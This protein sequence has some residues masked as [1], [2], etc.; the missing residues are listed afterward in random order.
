MPDRS[1]TEAPAFPWFGLIVLSAAVFMSVT[2]EM[3]PTGLLQPISRELGVT[4]PQV[5][6]LLTVFA[7][8]VVVSSIPLAALTRNL[9]RHGLLVVVLL[10]LAVSNLLS[11]IAPSYGF[12]VVARVLGG[13]AH[14]M[15]WIIVTAYAG[16][17]V[18][19]G[20]LGRAVA[21]TAGG[22]TLAYIFGVPLGTVLGQLLGWRLA[23]I[24]LAVLTVLAAFLVWKFVPPVAR[25]SADHAA[26]TPLRRDPTLPAVLIVCA[27]TG[28][29]MLGHYAL[30]TYIAP[31]LTD[32]LLMPESM[33]GLMLGVFGVAGAV[34]VV[35][36]GTV[37][38]HRPTAGL[39]ILL[40]AVLV[41][42]VVMVIGAS[43]LPVAIVAF[44]IWG[45][46]F[47]ALP[48]I[49]S[50]RML[51]VAS[52]R[53]RDASSAIYNSAFN[54]GIGGGALLGAALYNSVGV[55]QLPWLYAGTLVLALAVL[56]LTEL[57]ARR[58][59]RLA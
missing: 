29:V 39:V 12:I 41:S 35:L 2:N 1:S 8:T 4:E 46:A 49:L 34:G 7:G 52:A 59:T 58:R 20:Q 3:L 28:L 13:L 30:Y 55:G 50:T 16:H 11:A 10:V 21:I 6:L 18:P 43:A 24:V 5:G 44:T 37:F 53:A 47:G 57:R 56:G 26:T 42:V 36:V 48:S 31:F 54:F 22:G 19:R 32:V 51:H 23:W 25:D 45:I 9:P 38:G 14:A 15:F 33:I 27:V 17:L 40:I